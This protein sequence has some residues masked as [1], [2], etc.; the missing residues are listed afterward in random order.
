MVGRPRHRLE[1][2]IKMD[3]QGIGWWEAVSGLMDQ[4][5]D[6]LWALV[7]VVMNLQIPTN[8]E[9]LTICGI[10]TFSR[11]TVLHGVS[12]VCLYINYQ[13]DALIIIYS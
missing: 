2:S 10:A 7:Y 6:R 4:D 5:R 11:R 13:L 1:D 8:A 9:K 12:F 3:L